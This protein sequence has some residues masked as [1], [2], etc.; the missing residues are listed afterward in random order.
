MALAVGGSHYCDLSRREEGNAQMALKPGA[1]RD[2]ITFVMR[3]SGM[4]S[5]EEIQ[6]GVE[7]VLGQPVPPSSVRSYLGEHE[8]REFT[9]VS[10]GVYQLRK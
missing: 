8:G 6:A 5:V 4:M 10:R 7:R 1:V 2:A 9:R 3:G